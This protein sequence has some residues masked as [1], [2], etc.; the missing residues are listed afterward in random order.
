MTGREL[1]SRLARVLLPP[2]AESPLVALRVIRRRKSTCKSSVIGESKKQVFSG[3]HYKAIPLHL[4]KCHHLLQ[5]LRT[6]DGRT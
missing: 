6:L 2:K 4:F 5:A 3:S 1:E